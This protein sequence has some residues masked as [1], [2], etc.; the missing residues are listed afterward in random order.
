MCLD[1]SQSFAWTI[2]T[3]TWTLI[4]LIDLLIIME[5][6]QI[7][8]NTENNTEQDPSKWRNHISRSY[9][10]K[11]TLN[12]SSSMLLYVSW[13]FTVMPPWSNV[14]IC[15]GL[16]AKISSSHL[17]LM[18]HG[19]SQHQSGSVQSLYS[20]CV[21]CCFKRASHSAKSSFLTGALSSKHTCDWIISHL[22][23][24][25]CHPHEHLFKHPVN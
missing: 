5:F 2:K 25:Q 13:R 1:I 14:S 10:W 7:L 20:C 4:I 16:V 21:F 17:N 6:T 18:H 3:K 9:F 19:G 15:G 24:S 11:T 23:I 12:L 22:P 8:Q